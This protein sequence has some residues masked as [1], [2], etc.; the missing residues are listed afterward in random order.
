MYHF[1]D[2]RQSETFKKGL[3]WCVIWTVCYYT[4]G[5]VLQSLK[6]SAC[7]NS[8]VTPNRTAKPQVLFDHSTIGQFQSFSGRNLLAYFITPIPRETFNDAD[9]SCSIKT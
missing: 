4:Y 7:T 3:S 5:S 2:A 6:I 9:T 8:T 1:V